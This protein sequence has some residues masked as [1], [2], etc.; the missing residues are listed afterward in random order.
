MISMISLISTGSILL[1]A[2]LLA[3]QDPQDPQGPTKKE[4][5]AAQGQPKKISAGDQGQPKEGEEGKGQSID[6]KFPESWPATGGGLKPIAGIK[7]YRMGEEGCAYVNG[8][9]DL[10]DLDLSN[11]DLDAPVVARVN[12]RVITQD[13]FRLWHAVFAGQNGINTTQLKIL[14]DRAVEKIV[15]NGEDGSKYEVGEEEVDAKIKEEDEA[16]RLQGEAALK[17]YKERI[18]NTLGWEHYRIFVRNYLR[19]EKLLLPKVVEAKDGVEDLEQ[20]LPLESAELLQD[21]QNLLSYLTDAYLKGEPIPDMFRDQFL[22]MLQQKVVERADIKLALQYDLPAGVFMTV[23][24][25]PVTVDEVLKYASKMDVVRQAALRLCLLY[26]AI[27]DALADA[28]ATVSYEEFEPIF[29]AHEAEFVG[30]LFPLPNIAAMRGFFNMIEYREF[31]RRRSAFERMMK[32]EVTDDVLRKHHDSAGKLFYESGKVDCDA[33]WVSLV[34]TE[35]RFGLTGAD[36]WEKARER[37]DAAQKALVDG[38]DPG[39]I[40]EQYCSP[41][42]MIDDKKPRMRNE[43]RTVF[44]ETEY[45]ILRT[46]YSVAD[47]IFYNREEGEV[48]GPRLVLTAQQPGMREGFGYLLVRVNRFGYTTTKKPFEVQKPLLVSDYFD[49][50]FFYF[51]QQCLKNAS[52]GLTKRAR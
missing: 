30:T 10:A 48:I 27:D 14:T 28:G 40:R 42:Q 39:K 5:E 24:G 45:S 12:G 47:D 34:E 4:G 3:P 26:H 17:S 16:A 35:T 1:S 29:K 7:G 23:E 18:E 22:K 11:V 8:P 49:L 38:E 50:K 6:I 37:I 52:I 9:E 43:L 46:G 13:E 2:L 32:D 51:A 15:Q 44:G 31:F 20:G 21:Q 33:F 19:S 41:N 25:V 36:A